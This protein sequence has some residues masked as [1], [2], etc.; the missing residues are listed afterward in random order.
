MEIKESCLQGV[1]V[2]KPKVFEDQRGHFFESYNKKEFE[3]EVGSHPNFV[4]D[5][6]S[7]S[8]KDV[9]RGMHFQVNRPQGKLIRVTKGEIF[10]VVVDLRKDSKTFSKWFSMTLSEEKREQL[11][12][13]SGL[14]HGFIVISEYA[15]V[16]YKTTDYWYPDF[17]KTLLWN[18]PQVGIEWP[19]T[20]PLLSK[21]DS[22]GLKLSELESLL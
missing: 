2:I 8:K 19:S 14:A 13:P 22:Q 6:Y 18:D 5:N 11:W 10:D 16:A 17:E 9:L 21:K 15:E 7:R 4:Q 1:K 3:K 20:K 12:V